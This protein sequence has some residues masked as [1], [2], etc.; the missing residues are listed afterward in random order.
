MAGL[1]PVIAA[2]ERPFGIDQH[3][4]NVLDIADFGHAAPD[5]QQGVVCRRVG[6]R[7]VEQQNL[8]ELRAETGC[9]VPVFALDVVD[10]GRGRPGQ[11][12]RDDK[13]DAL[14]AAGRREAEDVLRTVVAKIALFMLAQHGTMIAQQSRASNLG[15][16]SPSCG[17][18]RRRPFQ[19]ARAPHRHGDRRSHGNQSAGSSN[20]AARLKDLRG[21]SFEAEPPPE[22]CRRRI[23]RV[24][25][26]NAHRRS[27]FRLISQ[28]R[29]RP[30]G[31]T[32]DANHHD[33]QNGCDLP[34]ENAGS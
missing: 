20:Q 1:L 14:A 26:G 16:I 34:P 25:E 9:Q 19:F 22:N 13:P 3:V 12:G 18:E 24:T 5:F 8:A 32:P 21:I 31:G 11:Q 28:S 2:F 33:E 17:A 30:L 23:D 27:Q 10:D 6:I 15:L 29:C 7:G 4:G